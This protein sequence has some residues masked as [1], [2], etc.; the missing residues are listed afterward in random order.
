MV[1][2]TFKL[3]VP[4]PL[5]GMILGRNGNIIKQ[6]RSD[7]GARVKIS[8]EFAGMSHA[9][10]ELN[11]PQTTTRGEAVM[12]LGDCILITSTL[13]KRMVS[14]YL[15]FYLFISLFILSLWV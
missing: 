15:F 4:T 13:Q 1:E 5:V 12:V 6:I 14:I 8:T 10:R 7:T 9:L 3:I 2:T 11:T